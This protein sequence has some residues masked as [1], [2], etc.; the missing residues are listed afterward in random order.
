M[1]L[2]VS[3]IFGHSDICVGICELQF[4]LNFQFMRWVFVFILCFSVCFSKE[5]E[6]HNRGTAVIPQEDAPPNYEQGDKE[7]K[8]GF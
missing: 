3:G 4:S 8:F 2:L 7:I 1:A 6:I 5:G